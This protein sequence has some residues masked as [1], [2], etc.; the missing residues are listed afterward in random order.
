MREKLRKGPPDPYPS[1]CCNIKPT[2]SHT[3]T[4]KHRKH[5]YKARVCVPHPQTPRFG[6]FS[7]SFLCTLLR[8]ETAS[9]P[10]RDTCSS[11]PDSPSGLPSRCSGAPAPL[12]PQTPPGFVVRR[13]LSFYL[14]GGAASDAAGVQR[15]FGR[16]PAC[17]AFGP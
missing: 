8:P 13:P 17:N 12:E 3:N 2:C 5:D 7:P 10:I 6:C 14:H 15:I 11:G 1:M 9:P 16:T 4:D